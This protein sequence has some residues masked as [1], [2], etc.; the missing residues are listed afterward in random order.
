MPQVLSLEQWVVPVP[1]QPGSL[2]GVMRV[3]VEAA[4]VHL[5]LGRWARFGQAGSWEKAPS[6][7]FLFG[8]HLSHP[9]QAL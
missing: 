4:M 6:P 2:K 7:P 8:P 9:G 5:G 3:V 1:D